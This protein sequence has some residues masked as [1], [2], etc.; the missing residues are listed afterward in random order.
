MSFGSADKIS[1]HFV[2][3][4]LLDLEKEYR[5]RARKEIRSMQ[6][7]FDYATREIEKNRENID[8]LN[9]KTRRVKLLL[10]GSSVLFIFAFFNPQIL[11]CVHRVCSVCSHIFMTIFR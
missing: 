9:G 2:R 3:S 7:L 10:I 4:I 8:K 6:P 1:P 5:E 11:S